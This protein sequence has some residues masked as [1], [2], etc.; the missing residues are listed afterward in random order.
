MSMFDGGKAAA[1]ESEAFHASV[2]KKREEKLRDEFA[3]AALSGI[4]A[5]RDDDAVSGEPMISYLSRG[6]STKWIAEMA[7]GIADAMMEA[8]K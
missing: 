8:R 3:M 5:N 1:E 6:G 2:R 7:Y 4:L